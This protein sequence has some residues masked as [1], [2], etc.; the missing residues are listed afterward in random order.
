MISEGRIG[1]HV[2]G[3]GRGLIAGTIPAFGWRDCGKPQTPRPAYPVF[4]LRFESRTSRIQTSDV[5]HSTITSGTIYVEM[6]L[7]L[8]VSNNNY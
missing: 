4:G 5:Y 2:E 3:S 8:L 7:G 6:S 1:K